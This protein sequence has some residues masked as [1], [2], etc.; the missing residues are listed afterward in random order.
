MTNLTPQQL[1]Q[2]WQTRLSGA[3]EQIRAG[4]MAVQEAPGV[5][6]AAQKAKYVQRVQ[7]RADKWA[8]RVAAVSLTAWK[9]AMINKGLS[10]ISGGAQAAI[11]KFTAFM[12][13]WMSFQRNTVQP[14]LQ[15]M[16]RNTL[17]DNINRAVFVIRANAQFGAGRRGVQAPGLFG[18][19][20]F[21]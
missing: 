1:A 18:Q 3:G 16:P 13:E 6:A 20:L 11:P 5:K 21:Q 2:K 15:S 9:D 19:P 10:R 7:E 4:V 17:D 14:A 12:A 8:E